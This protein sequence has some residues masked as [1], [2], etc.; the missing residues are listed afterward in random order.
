MTDEPRETLRDEEIE[1]AR[2]PAATTVPDADEADQDADADD[3]GGDDMDDADTS[4]PD[5]GPADSAS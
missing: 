5:V 2:R 1:T 4:D 3:P